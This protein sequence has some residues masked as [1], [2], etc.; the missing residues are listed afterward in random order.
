MKDEKTGI[1]TILTIL[2][3]IS[4]TI[5]SCYG[6]FVTTTYARETPSM[7]AQ[8]IGQDMADLFFVVPLLLISLVFIRRNN[9]V[10]FYIFGGTLFYILYSFVIYS[11]GV[12]FNSLF[13]LYCLTLGL[14][15]YAFIL[16]M[17]MAGSLNVRD[18]FHEKMPTGI[19]GIYLLLISM[20]F[21]FL[22]LK[23]IVPALLT[24]TI[25]KSVSDYRL[26]VNPV[27]VIDLAVALPGLI[28]ASVLL[29]KKHRLGYL[30]AP[31]ALVFII[32]MAI[33]LAVMVLAMKYK[34]INEDASVAVIF[35]VIAC[36]SLVFLFSFFRRLQK[37]TFEQSGEFS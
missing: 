12:H 14:S 8:G 27:H 16:F 19:T 37:R 7:A 34:G 6:A 21:Y 18:W 2:L 17:N 36:I 11:F 25:P 33:A 24:N 3:A 35:I 5:V 26:L 1:I 13:L 10:A 30:L 22:W 29:M 32:L 28:I 9:I 4:L 31:V 15:L 20:M 23:E